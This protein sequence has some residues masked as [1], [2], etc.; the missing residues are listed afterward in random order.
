MASPSDAPTGGWSNQSAAADQ[1]RRGSTLLVLALVLALLVPALILVGAAGFSNVVR[2][3]ELLVVEQLRAIAL[4]KVSQIESWLTERRQ[5]AELVSA[6]PV[7]LRHLRRD[8]DAV[9]DA[10]SDAI[11]AKDLAGTYLLFNRAAAGFCA[12]TPEAALGRDD[13]AIFPPEQAAL[14]IANDRPVMAQDRIVTFQEELTTA[15]GSITFLATKG[16]LYD[17]AGRVAGLFGIARDITE[18]ARAE[19][20]NRTQ[21]DELRRWQRLVPGREARI[22]ELKQE[23][24]SLL[25]QTG[26]GPRYAARPAGPIRTDPC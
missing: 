13:Q 1:R 3:H 24:N 21:L 5:D 8:G 6:S 26:Q 15:Q 9:V 16:P 19:E 17:A 11:Y 7:L 22:L 23:V 20:A 2:G 25:A 14:I 18:R 10:S 4:P 12:I